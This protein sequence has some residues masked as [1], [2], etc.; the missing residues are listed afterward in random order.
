[1]GNTTRTLASVLGV[2]V[3]LASSKVAIAG[4]EDEKNDQ[5]MGVI[6]RA[7]DK[8]QP[9]PQL[10]DGKAIVAG[11]S[12]TAVS[13]HV[14]ACNN[15]IVQFNKYYPQITA[16]GKATD[17]AKKIVSRVKALDPHCRALTAAGNAY[18]T[19]LQAK[20]KAA[21]D[22]KAAAKAR[23]DAVRREAFKA[24]SG[25][26]MYDVLD[27]WSG[28]RTPTAAE[29]VVEFRKNL[30]TLAPVCKPMADTVAACK[31]YGILQ[32]S[33]TNK[34]YSYGDICAPAIDTQKTLTDVA[35]RLLEHLAG[36]NAR[37]LPTADS[38]RRKEG[39]L[40][41]QDVVLYNT[42]FTVSDE[43]KQALMVH[44]KA[45]FDAA[46]VEPP[47]D[48]SGLW[49]NQQAFLDAQKA[50][51]DQTAGEWA[52]D[53]DK[54]KGY[55]CNLAK[56]S[57][58]KAYKGASIKQ[59]YGSNWRISKNSLGVPLERYHKMFVVYKVKGEPYCQVR[60]FTAHE[61]YKGGGK[62]QKAKGAGWGYVRFQ[63]KC[64]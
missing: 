14:R 25:S 11:A 27:T 41:S 2:A 30:E 10:F 16:K 8:F 23:C 1:M 64:K 19:D 43:K 17:R 9:D 49:A 26:A 36:R 59:V 61:P 50:A 32:S 47:K 58:K 33:A 53:G 63:A 54:C 42:Y 39:W 51:V 7:V 13:N 62:Y 6:E 3:L 55:Q 57:I 28:G 46:G 15:A 4:Y 20:E 22:A 34:R 48:L 37:E 52:I 21:A 29:H 31:G 5:N 18:I 44:V 45:A 24:L 35:M 60:S 38:F 40:H 56:R 12:P